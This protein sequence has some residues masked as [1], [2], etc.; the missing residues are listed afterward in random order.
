MNLD[1]IK[2]GMTVY[3]WEYP[4]KVLSIDKNKKTAEVE[5]N[6][7]PTNHKE[8]IRTM[9]IILLELSPAETHGG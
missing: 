1:E 5:E 6:G 2:I 9:P 4:V 7:L 3:D 8:R